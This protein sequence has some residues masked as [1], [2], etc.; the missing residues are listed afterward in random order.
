MSF[1]LLGIC[2]ILDDDKNVFFFYFSK[3]HTLF[4]YDS[5]SQGKTQWQMWNANGNE[6]P[7]S[8]P[9]AMQKGKTKI[10]TF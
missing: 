3:F 1:Y 5:F 9:G 4:I 10:I 6:N 7:Y 2:C 8:Y